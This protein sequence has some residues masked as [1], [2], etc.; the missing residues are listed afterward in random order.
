M[1]RAALLLQT[2]RDRVCAESVLLRAAAGEGA[3]PATRGANRRLLPAVEL[4]RPPLSGGAS[5]LQHFY[6]IA[7]CRVTV[8]L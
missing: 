3:V 2:L 5:E 6:L 8:Y 4:P 1:R 7:C